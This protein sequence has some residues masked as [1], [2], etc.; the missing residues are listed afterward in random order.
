MLASRSG[1]LAR[2]VLIQLVAK[3]DEG[4][5]LRILRPRILDEAVPPSRQSLERLRIRDVVDQG[6]AISAA[7][8]GVAERLELLLPCRIPN[9]QRHHRVVY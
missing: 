9:L 4:E 2:I 1:N 8:E 3:A 6:A 5:R 7:V